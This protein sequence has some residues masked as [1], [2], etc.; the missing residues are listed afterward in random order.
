VNLD[1]LEALCREAARSLLAREGRPLPA[2]VVLPLADATK[3]TTLP[4]LPDDDGG[5]RA[6]LGRFADDVMRPADAPCYGLIAEGLAEDV[7]VVVVVYGA[8]R[9]HPR[10]TAAPLDGDEVGDFLP[11]EELDPAAMPFVAALQQ[12]VEA[13]APAS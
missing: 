13:A 11:A 3:I 7:E 6:L 9:H 2:A 12:A 4:D 1:E 5:R 10:V 8:R